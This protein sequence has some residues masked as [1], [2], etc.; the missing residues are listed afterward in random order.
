LIGFDTNILLYAIDSR[1]GPKHATAAL[2]LG[3]AL[4]SAQALIPLQA[5]GEFFH[6]ATRKLGLA[7][8]EARSFIAGWRATARIEPYGEPDLD[9][10]MTASEQ[11]G[12]AFWDALIWSVCERTGASWLV[13]E[14]FQHG[15]RL[16]RVTFVDPFDPAQVRLLD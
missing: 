9:L 7:K 12:L 13:S 15:R 6:V 2:A 4:A 8:P 10:A 5:L 11:H 1:A 14:D 16:G 3:R